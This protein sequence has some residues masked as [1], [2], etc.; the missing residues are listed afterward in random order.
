MPSSDSF[1]QTDRDSEYTATRELVEE[2]GSLLAGKLNAIY[3]H[4]RIDTLVQTDSPTNIVRDCNGT[5][6]LL[7]MLIGLLLLLLLLLS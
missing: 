7:L 2:T 5:C 6:E 3:A 1:V 4:L